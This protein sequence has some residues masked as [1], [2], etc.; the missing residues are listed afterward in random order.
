VGGLVGYSN[1]SISY[2]FSTGSV[3]GGS[4]AS[5]VGGLLGYLDSYGSVEDAYAMGAV[6]AGANSQYL[7]GLIGGAPRYTSLTNTYSTGAVTAGAAS[8]GLDGAIGTFGGFTSAYT[9][10]LWD[11][12]TSGRAG[13]Q[14]YST[15]DPLTT[16]QLQGTASLGG[17][18]VSLAGF[19]GGAAGGTA[20]LYPYLTNFYPNGVQSISGV[21]YTN[22]VATP[23]ASGTGGAGVVSI[24]SNGS[25]LSTADTGVNGYYYSIVPAGTLAANQNVVA[26]TQANASTGALDGAQFTQSSGGTSATIPV[27]AGWMLERVG[28]IGSL[29]ALNAAYAQAVGATAGASLAPANVQITGSG[30]FDVD[31]SLT[32]TGTVLLSFQG[33]VNETG[34]ATLTAAN[35]LL[36]GT[37]GAYVLSDT[38]AIGTLAAST[39]SVSLVD[40]S[41]LTTGSL[42]GAAG[43][44]TSGVST[45]GTLSVVSGGSITLASGDGVSGQSPV[46]AAS[47]AFINAAGS[48]GVTASSGRW[49]IY[50]SAPGN[51]SFGA[52]NSNDSAIFGASYST[53]APGAVS[54]GG[55][56]YV[57]ANQPV[58]TVTPTSDTK[59][60]GV[61]D[62]GSIAG[63]YSI[64]GFPSVSGVFLADTV[65]NAVSGSATVTSLGSGQYAAVSG[66]PYAMSVALNTLAASGYSFQSAAGGTL[67][68]TPATITVS[69]A[70]GVNKPYDGG[71]ALV[72]GAVGFTSSGVLPLDAGSVSITAGGDVYAG[73]NAGLQSINVTGLSLSGP[74]AGNYTLSSTTATGSGTIIP[75]VLN[76]SG[77]RLYDANTDAAAGVFES[78]GVIAGVAG[79]L[80][81]LT[82]TGTLAGKNVG[83]ESVTGLGSLA[84]GNGGSGATAGLASNYTLVGGTDAVSVTAFP[85]TVSVTAGNKT[86]DATPAASVTLSSSGVFAGDTVSFSDTSA[87]F[88]DA[89]VGTGKTVTVTGIGVGGT[90][91]G[92][93]SIGNANATA[94]T[95]ANITPASITAVTGITASNK[96]YDGSVSASLNTGAAM[97]VGELSGDTL[98]VAGASGAFSDPN[99]G[100]G[101]TVQI[102]GITLGG[103]D[104]GDYVLASNTASSMANI[105][106]AILNLSGTRVYDAGTDAA[107]GIF[108]SNGTLNAVA[109]QTLTLTGAGVLA[110]RSVGNQ[111]LSSLG[112]LALL[113]GSGASAG[114]AS[115]Y[116][117]AGGIDTVNVTP[118]TIA[119]TG[120]T[121]VNKTYDGTTALP[122]GS[123]GFIATGIYADDAAAITIG[124][125]HA[126]Y[127]NAAVGAEPIYVS[128]L[129]LS[130][131]AAGN[132]VLSSSTAS[133]SGTITAAS[134]AGSSG[135]PPVGAQLTEDSGKGWASLADTAAWSQS[136][137]PM[138]VM[139]LVRAPQQEMTW[140]A[141]AVAAI[142]SP[143]FDQA[144][145]CV[146]HE[147]V[148]TDGGGHET[149]RLGR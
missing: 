38:N 127:A 98:T 70:S 39:G 27:F 107:A 137:H 80:L 139:P 78:N 26:F 145:V 85:L 1:G 108:G 72:G 100:S 57:F 51:D 136:G 122:A 4:A 109:G 82:G 42:S 135:S 114:L 130:G 99:A 116:T 5:Y 56:R 13:I 9:A 79:Q 93:Y 126:G 131:A 44:V 50:S 86:Y 111:P 35:L 143:A 32:A 16:A 91:G 81:T 49:L 120:A 7:G 41:S 48:S 89:N 67:S 43:A 28:T 31:T 121:G 25:L 105:T 124:A 55:D 90:D 129:T 47:G 53:L 54:Q 2:V 62:S 110:G 8:S 29:S 101:K 30:G 58:L 19:S 60:Y 45:T 52:L 142:G 87:S 146:R 10:P 75:A 64:T 149:S 138:D 125:A 123:S 96:S 133:G 24:A 88:A 36:A 113:N 59:M 147:C 84:L 23:L 94:T 21:A 15:G 40:G 22:S 68:V 97:F 11:T 14:G 77:T 3:S 46:L 140:G 118:A 148:A 34:G 132:Y 74:A 104:A 71:P 61:D 103:T 63:D 33:S 76:L 95:T 6:T 18:S 115:N 69:G 73:S 134:S 102:S 106:P 12:T 141:M 17:I 128:G 144:V 66:S 117:L 37:G 92:N 112:T 119:V 83:N 65:A 20:G